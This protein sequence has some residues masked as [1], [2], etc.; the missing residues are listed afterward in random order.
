MNAA[1]EQA[2]RLKA[3]QRALYNRVKSSVVDWRALQEFARARI[4]YHK[5]ELVSVDPNKAAE[6][7]ALQGAIAECRYLVNLESKIRELLSETPPDV[8]ESETLSSN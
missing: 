5:N 1:E 6:V 7:A 4:E 8:E 3:A 2:A